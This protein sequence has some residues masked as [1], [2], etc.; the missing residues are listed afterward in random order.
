MIIQKEENINKID[1]VN[2][3]LRI[4]ELIEKAN[5]MYQSRYF[6]ITS[7][8]LVENYISNYNSKVMQTLFND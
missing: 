2:M 8:T 1:F 3:A 5:K 4:K 6:N 7:D